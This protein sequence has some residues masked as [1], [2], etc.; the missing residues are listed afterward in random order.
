VPL[1]ADAVGSARLAE[2]VA[3]ASVENRSPVAPASSLASAI[4]GKTYRFPANEVGLRSMKLDL[5]STSP[6]YDS[7]FASADGSLLR[8]EGPIGLDGTY[9]VREARGFE[10]LLAVKGNWLSDDTFRIVAR[11]LLEGV[12]TTYVLTF[13]GQRV[14]VSLEDNRGVHARLRGEAGE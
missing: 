3:D 11:S 7:N 13:N 6:R 5:A 9:R 8:L 2:R 10:P 1:A 12:V 4:S 14:D